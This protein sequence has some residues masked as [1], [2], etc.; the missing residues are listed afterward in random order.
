MFDTVFGELFPVQR[1]YATVD[2]VKKIQVIL[3]IGTKQ[4]QGS[5]GDVCMMYP[6]GFVIFVVNR[7][8][9]FDLSM[10]TEEPV[11][12]RV[13]DVDQHLKHPSD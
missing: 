5:V 3:A 2:A 6:V 10:P 7:H 12:S 11:V 1:V 13:T 8:K 4:W 9:V